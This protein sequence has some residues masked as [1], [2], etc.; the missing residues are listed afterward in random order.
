MLT[1]LYTVPSGCQVWNKSVVA[2][3]GQRFAYC[4]TLSIYVYAQSEHGGWQ[5]EKILH[6]ADETLG[7]ITWNP[8]SASEFAVTVTDHIVTWDVDAEAEA[9]RV[10]VDGVYSVAWAQHNRALVASGARDGRLQLH[11]L[12]AGTTSLIT[13]FTHTP[14]VLRWSGRTSRLGVGTIGGCV[15]VLAQTGSADQKG[16]SVRW[17][18]HTK[19]KA[20]V[21]DVAW[22]PCSEHY[23]LVAS[24]D[25]ELSLVDVEARVPVQSFEA[26]LPRAHHALAWMP[27]APGSFVS[28]ASTS[29]TVRL[30]NVSH[31][32][33]TS[34]LRLDRSAENGCHALAFVADGSRRAVVTFRSGAVG[35][36]DLERRY[37]PFVAT[38][39]HTDTVFGA[40][41]HPTDPNRVASAAFDGSARLWEV[42]AGGGGAADAACIA[43]FFA[44][45][46]AVAGGRA[47]GGGGAAAG[48]ADK[49]GDWRSTPHPKATPPG[50]ASKPRGALYA[51]AWE[52]SRGERLAC[53]SGVGSLIVW[54]V[55]TG[56]AGAA[57]QVRAPRR[58]AGPA[59]LAAARARARGRPRAAPPRAARPRASSARRCPRR[60]RRCS[61]WTGARSSRSSSAWAAPTR[62]C[63]CTR[64]TGGAGARRFCPQPCT[65]WRGA[66]RRPRA[67][68]AARR[69]TR[70]RRSRARATTA[71]CACTPCSASSPAASR[72]PSRRC[73][74]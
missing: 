17:Q 36:Y 38:T 67:R 5:L 9:G 31:K 40:R 45:S 56:Q 26:E 69:R 62:A 59:L 41:F 61:A 3:H 37:W 54:D 72:S 14:T 47:G 25:G 24:L 28:I 7:G 58:A 50:V 52:P 21:T 13:T 74:R 71:W 29:S 68:R 30:W 16:T 43:T 42:C 53:V 39:G 70:W 23:M 57:V 51:C 49:F 55:H 20:P 6:G 4:A 22:D 12:T 73:T 46:V 60:R 15:A 66:L 44:D 27:G 48:G 35:V 10:R 18:Y 65:A 32:A 34:T 11:D 19:D 1:Q 63:T 8:A 2:T 64:P 33:P